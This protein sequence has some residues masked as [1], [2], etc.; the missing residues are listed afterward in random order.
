VP[1]YRF[2]DFVLSPRRRLLL[3]DGREQ[4][5][6]PRYFDLLVFLIEHRGTAVH[7][8]DIFDAV[9]TDVVVSDSALSQAVR[10]IRRVL[11]D[12]PREPRFVRTVSRHGYQFVWTDVVEE[13][14]S[15]DWPSDADT[16]RVPRPSTVATAVAVTAPPDPVEALLAR[17]A[18][19]AVT[20][21]E[22]EEQ[23]DAAERLHAAGTAEA[24]QRL[25]G[26][27]HPA[28]ARA[29]LRD[30]RWDTPE[31]GPV[32][33]LGTPASA[34]VVWHLVRIRLRR[35]AS[36]VRRRWA[37]AAA[38]GALAGA[39]GGCIGG[40]MLIAAPGSAASLAVLPVLA[41]IG[42]ACGAVAAAGIGAGLAV[43]ESVTRSWRMAG[44]VIGGALG[45]G[46]V[47]LAIELLSRWSLDVLVGNHTPIGGGLEGL[48]I[49][50]G[51]AFGYGMAT[52][53]S[54]DGTPAPRGRERTRV[55]IA[56]AVACAVAALAVSLTGRP[57]V[58][59]TIHAIA[60]ASAGQQAL[61][62]PLGRLIGE[63]GFGPITAA[64]IATGEGLAFG[65]GLALGLTRRT[66][67]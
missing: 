41:A 51:A 20:A 42:T 38:G 26:L 46:T 29:L 13:D 2:S 33:I 30:T 47:G 36:L 15:A 25:Q 28:F 54:Q 37:G 62:S 64:L 1:R 39:A 63:P 19:P 9:W 14:E 40:L 67:R 4:P 18:R 50:A 55:A 57:L 24:L 12:D 32:P 48:V 61:L 44:T 21:D 22:E 60:Q 53:R 16:S 31:S 35:T 52:R 34:A 6:I 56:T 43:S 5:L 23:R 17:I 58:G 10:T 8:R 7:R 49:G 65:C 11:D 27:A 59:G 3:R 66:A 45:G